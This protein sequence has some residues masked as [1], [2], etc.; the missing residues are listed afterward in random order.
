MGT[1][2]TLE[3]EYYRDV[4][5]MFDSFHRSDLRM[6]ASFYHGGQFSAL[7]AFSSSGSITQG[8]T[9]E[10]LEAALL[11]NI[12]T[13][14]AEDLEE[15]DNMLNDPMYQ[16]SA[17]KTLAA[18]AK[19]LEENQCGCWVICDWTSTAMFEGK[20]FESFDIAE[21]YLCEFFDKVSLDYDENRG[22]YSIVEKT[23]GC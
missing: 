12:E 4:T 14:I 19:E 5:G 17:L 23:I 16:Q 11:V 1:T 18:I 15:N 6:I 9:S 3:N 8:L 7:Y 20:V 2:K 21:E 10:A 13:E 22:E